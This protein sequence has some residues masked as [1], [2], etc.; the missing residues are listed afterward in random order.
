LWVFYP[1]VVYNSH[2]ALNHRE[3]DALFQFKAHFHL[4]GV[5][6][7]DNI[8][9]FHELADHLQVQVYFLCKI[10]ILEQ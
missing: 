5:K 6:V 7:V 3:G 9:G 2:P 10:F 8:H 4:W 1:V